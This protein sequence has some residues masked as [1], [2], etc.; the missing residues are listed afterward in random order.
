MKN[1]FIYYASP[2]NREAVVHYEATIRRPVDQERIFEHADRATARKL[3][4][5]FGDRPIPTW[6]QSGGSF[7]TALFSKMNPGDLI[8]LVE[9][10][11]IKLLGYIACKTEN[12]ALSRALWQDM[13]GTGKTWPLVYFIANAREIDVPFRE[14]AKLVGYSENYQLRGFTNVKEDRLV[15]FHAKY[16]DLYSILLRIKQGMPV[17]EVAPQVE[18]PQTETAAPLIDDPLPQEELPEQL[19]SDHV[20]MQ[21][22]ILNMGRKAGEKVWVPKNDQ[23]KITSNYNFADF[24]TIFAAGLDTQTKYVENIDVVWKEEFKIDAAFEIENSTSV[25]SGLLRFADLTMVAPNTLYP[26]FI[27]APSDRRGVVFEQLKRPSFRK[28]NI[29]NKVRYLS[30]EAVNEIDK[31]FGEKATGLNVNVLMDK[32]EQLEVA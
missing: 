31:F 32:A 9:G 25:Y 1:V 20:Q 6:G 16:D 11:T 8:M 5:I 4:E 17:E 29:S 19:I 3:K 13:S 15:A 12:E 7:G 2:N 27:V 28:L 22:K 18:Y 30:Y 26:M 10:P 21:W 23:K 14:F 24:E